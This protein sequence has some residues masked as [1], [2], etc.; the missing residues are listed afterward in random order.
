MVNIS[1]ATLMKKAFFDDS[2]LAILPLHSK[3]FIVHGNYLTCFV[4]LNNW[5]WFMLPS[6]PKR[7]NASLQAT[8][9]ALWLLPMGTFGHVDQTLLEKLNTS[10][11]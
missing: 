3:L 6:P 11:L 5:V 10:L 4:M 2:V 1:N 8:M 7:I 9:Q